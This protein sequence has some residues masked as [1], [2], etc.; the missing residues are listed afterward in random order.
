M[1]ESQRKVKVAIIFVPESARNALEL[2]RDIGMSLL[3]Y[4]TNI[5]RMYV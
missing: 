1:L 4:R 2:T 5:D 3:L